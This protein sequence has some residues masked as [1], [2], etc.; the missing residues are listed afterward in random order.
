[1]A[2]GE[3]FDLCCARCAAIKWSCALMQRISV[4]AAVNDDDVAILLRRVNISF[5]QLIEH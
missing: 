2:I 3:N 5:G 4:K 1:M